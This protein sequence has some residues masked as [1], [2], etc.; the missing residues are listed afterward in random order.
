M[1]KRL[2]WDEIKKNFPNKWVGLSE[3]DWKDESNVRSAVVTYAGDSDVEP[4]KRQLAGEDIYAIYTTPDN[5]CPLGMLV[6]S[7]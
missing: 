2:S 6:S 4:L 7:K 3:V 5:L 1:K